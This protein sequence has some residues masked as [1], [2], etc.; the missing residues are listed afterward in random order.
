VRLFGRTKPLDV[1]LA[2]Q[3]LAVRTRQRDLAVNALETLVNAVGAVPAGYE[4][5]AG[6]RVA[7][8][9]DPRLAMAYSVT[10]SMLGD[11]KQAI[12]LERKADA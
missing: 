12:A 7:I 9:A 1:T 8:P 4:C 11:L 3:R 5:P 2:Q 6:H 10:V